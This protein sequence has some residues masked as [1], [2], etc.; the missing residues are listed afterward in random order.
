MKNT[1][2]ND[3]NFFNYFTSKE[4]FRITFLIL[5]SLAIFGR[6]QLPSQLEMISAMCFPFTNVFFHFIFLLV[7]MY[8]TIMICKTFDS[9]F[10]FIFI[11]YFSKKRK[12]YMIIKHV[13]YMTLFSFTIFLIIYFGLL[14]FMYTNGNVSINPF[15]NTT[16]IGLIYVYFKWI[17]LLFLIQIINSLLYMIIKEKII[18]IA[19]VYFV[20]LYSKMF[21]NINYNFLPWI[22]QNGMNWNKI[23]TDFISF[24][25]CIFLLVLTTVLLLRVAERI[26]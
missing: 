25:G 12:L 24:G 19:L 3:L 9:E 5:V 4:A 16:S 20:P 14:K 10:D 6:L 11:R 22:H 18:I 13:L 8:N 1:V 17:I 2:H 7:F 23:T 21:K 26:L 15:S